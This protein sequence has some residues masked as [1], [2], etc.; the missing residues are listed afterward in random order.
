MATLF[1]FPDIDI[2]LLYYLDIQSIMRLAM[3][4]KDNLIFNLNFV[5]QL[6]QI[7]KQSI[8]DIINYSCSYNYLS[9]IIWIH[10]SVNEFKY[11]KWAINYAAAHGNI[12]V[13][14]WFDKSSYKI[15]YD[16]NAINWG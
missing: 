15:L 2:Y 9:L 6:R 8:V 1:N 5:I 12:D 16:K 11:E 7:K 4:T 14:E 10:E 3:V 13:L